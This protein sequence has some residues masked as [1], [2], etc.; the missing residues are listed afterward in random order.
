M[1]KIIGLLMLTALAEIFDCFCVWFKKSSIQLVFSVSS[2][3][4]NLVC[5]FGYFPYPPEASGR[6]YATYGGIY[7]A[8]SI[9]WLKF[10]DNI[11]LSTFDLIGAGI[12]LLDTLVIVL[13]WRS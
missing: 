1:I 5:L 7:I 4:F 3:K 11:K 6:I 12:I 2:I 9:S 10:V 8:L 13:G